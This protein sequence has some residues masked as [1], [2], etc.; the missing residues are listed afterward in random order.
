MPVKTTKA[1]YG[2]IRLRPDARV[3][4]FVAATERYMHSTKCGPLRDDSPLYFLQAR[5]PHRH[6]F[7]CGTCLVH[8][9]E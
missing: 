7:E 4:P 9:I 1:Q 5:N 6:V 8:A 3:Q 2:Q